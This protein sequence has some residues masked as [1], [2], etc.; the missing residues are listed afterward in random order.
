M[1]TR[2]HVQ[3]APDFEFRFVPGILVRPPKEPVTDPVFEAVS[4]RDQIPIDGGSLRP[5]SRHGVGRDC[6][7][8]GN[9]EEGVNPV[10]LTET[11][12]CRF[13]RRGDLHD[14][15]CRSTS[16]PW[17]DRCQAHFTR[18]RADSAP[19]HRWLGA[20]KQNLRTPVDHDVDAT[21]HRPRM[22]FTCTQAWATLG[23]VL[24]V[25]RT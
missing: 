9:E 17:P 15:A 3:V 16:T 1:L 18:S 22:T 8:L 20:A 12:V 11:G 24:V 14:W 21:P 5:G 23:Q 7:A 25:A 13:P 2:T 10:R 6:S 19:A 4:Q